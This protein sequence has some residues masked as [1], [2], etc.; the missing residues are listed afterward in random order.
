MVVVIV[1]RE[2]ITYGS[3]WLTALISP[4]GI[5]GIKC[6]RDELFSNKKMKRGKPHKQ[7]TQILV[8]EFKIGN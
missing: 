7:E 5:I 8:G 1:H 4:Y 6:H 2:K 3:F